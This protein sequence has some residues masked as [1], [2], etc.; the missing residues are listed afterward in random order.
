MS[1]YAAPQVETI[2]LG[3]I[4]FSSA[5]TRRFKAPYGMNG[6]LVDVEAEVTTTMNGATLKVGKVGD[7]TANLDWTLPTGTAPQ[8]Y[9][10]TTDKASFG[11]DAEL[12]RLR[13]D[14]GVFQVTMD[15]T[16][17]VAHVRLIVEWF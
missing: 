15:G 12:T 16:A 1:G 6:R 3:A 5:Q 10:A 14:D 9:R 8:V 11:K 4:T 7:L 17:G 13:G 2:N